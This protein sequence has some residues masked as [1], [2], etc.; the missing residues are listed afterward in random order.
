MRERF[1]WDGCE[2]GRRKWSRGG[3]VWSVANFHHSRPFSHHPTVH[4]LFHP[5]Q[6]LISRFN[7]RISS[8]R[9][10]LSGGGSRAF[11]AMAAGGENATIAQSQFLKHTA[12]ERSIKMN[13]CQSINNALDIAL[14]NDET[15]GIIYCVWVFFIAFC[16]FLL[17]FIVFYC[18]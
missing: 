10:L 2:G 13:M 16:C 3:A 9:T 12:A 14:E 4:R 7:C 15:A 1:L 6:M 18:I 11:A 8:Y 5:S 17:H